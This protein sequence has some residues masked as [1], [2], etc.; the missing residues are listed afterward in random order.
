MTR[1]ETSIAR[2]WPG[3]I[4][5]DDGE[6]LTSTPVIEDDAVYVRAVL[7]T[8]VTL[9]LTVWTPA[10]SPIAIDGTFMSLR[11]SE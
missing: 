4:V 10:R 2:V 6:T 1:N 7:S 11:S 3:L 5:N 9:R 8:F